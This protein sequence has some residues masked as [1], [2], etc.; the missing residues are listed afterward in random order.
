MVAE[1]LV[2]LGGQEAGCVRRRGDRLTFEYAETWRRNPAAYP[3]SLSMPLVARQHPH[4]VIHAFIWGLL[5]DNDRTLERWAREFQVSARNAFALISH[6]GEDC[7]GAVQFVRPERMEEI[8]TG[9][10][11]EWID[12]AEVA[13]R[14]RSVLA[15]AATGRTVRDNGQFSL[16]GAQP[17]TALLQEGNRWGIPSGRIPTTHIL[18]PPVPSLPGNAENEHFCLQLGRSLGLRTVR[19]EV[20]RFEDQPVISVMRY[21]RVRLSSG[22]KGPTIERVHQEDMCQALAVHPEHK[23]ENEGGPSASAI[24]S[25]IRESVRAPGGN[26]PIT[27]DAGAFVDALLFNWLIGG[28]DAH[29][30]NYSFLIGSDGVVRLAPLYDIGSAFGLADLAPQRMRLAMKVGRHYRLDTIVLRH[31]WEWA[32]G[33]RL[34]PDAVTERAREMASRLP[35]EAVSIA[36]RM[37]A[38]GLNH[39]VIDRLVDQLAGRA[40][41]VLRM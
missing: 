12:E 31:W 27:M 23:Y 10:T 29:A 24:L 34:H 21:D 18:K 11:I 28:T 30:K 26:D 37:R 1:L 38:R 36:A 13:R 3:L 20:L 19:S 33:A 22:D 6:V 2:L 41:R 32:A 4:R 40:E 5:P 17:K 7:A 8:A 16:A 9:G 25:L 14:L 15:E 35:D 39:A